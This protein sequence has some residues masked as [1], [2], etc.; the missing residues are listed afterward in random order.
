MRKDENGYI[1]VE[2]VGAFIPFLLLVISIL[3][4]VNI[5]TLQ[6]RVHNAL[7]QAANTLSMYSYVLYATGAADSMMTM[8]SKAKATGESINSVLSG[9]ESL[10]KSNG[11]DADAGNRILSTAE[12]AAGDPKAAIQNI[13][14]YGAGRLRSSA[15]QQLV[16]PLVGR[17]LAG[18]DMSGEEYLNSVRVLNFDL[19]DCV[20]IDRNGNVKIT[21]DYEIE[22]TFGALRL[23]FGPTLKVTQTAVTKAWLNGSGEGYRG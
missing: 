19:S 1:V 14:N 16:M 13:L 20:I 7:T 21:V 22:Y 2:T 6:A 18:G 5:V 15:T 23:P 3:S 10:S 17:Y 11:F 12:K 9:I 4:L 8:D